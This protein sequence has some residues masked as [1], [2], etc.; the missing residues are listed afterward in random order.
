MQRN[1]KT[2]VLDKSDIQ[3][4]AER[5][6][7]PE[8]TQNDLKQ[9]SFEMYKTSD[10]VVGITESGQTV[11]LKNRWGDKGVVVSHSD[12]EKYVKPNYE[13][14]KSGSKTKKK[15]FLARIFGAHAWPF[16]RS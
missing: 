2:L 3:K 7:L 8:L 1:V 9:K 16:N 6:K 15:S 14:N 13:N 5:K 11:L 4:A 12:Y 10:L